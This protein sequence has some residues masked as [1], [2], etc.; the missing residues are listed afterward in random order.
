MQKK[1]LKLGDM[2]IIG[3]YFKDNYKD[4]G[5]VSVEHVKTFM[6]EIKKIREEL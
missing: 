4:F 2:A 3:S 6:D 1:Q 5:D